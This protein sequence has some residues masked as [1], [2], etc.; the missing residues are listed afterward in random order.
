MKK[1]KDVLDKAFDD[2][3]DVVDQTKLK[4]YM[5][6]VLDCSGSMSS[7]RDQAIEAFNQQIEEIKK[8]TGEMQTF[9]SLVTFSSE[10]DKPWLWCKNVEDAPLLTRENYIPDANTALYDAVGMTINKLNIKKYTDDPN[11]AFLMIIIS[12]GEENWS[13]EYK[14]K[15]LAKLVQSVQETGRWTF[16]YIGSRQDLAEE[17]I[18]REQA[19]AMGVSMAN[20]VGFAGMSG[21]TGAS[22]TSG[23]SGSALSVGIDNYMSSRSMGIRADNDLYRGYT[24]AEGVITYDDKNDDKKLVDLKD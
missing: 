12:D 17:R 2:L 15:D 1:S 24:A 19:G 13:K 14:S 11:A 16:T 5:A 20:V 6:F 23:T 22:G 4:N 21:F 10:V 3:K 18:L 8:T 9:V 7:M